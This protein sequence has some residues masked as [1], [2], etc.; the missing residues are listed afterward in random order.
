MCLQMKPSKW[1]CALQDI[2]IIK[3]GYTCMKAFRLRLSWGTG[4]P[5]QG[6]LP[7]S[8]LRAE[9]TTMKLRLQQEREKL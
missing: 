8:L 7:G 3:S 5:L 2:F 4:G 1:I 6:L 9:T